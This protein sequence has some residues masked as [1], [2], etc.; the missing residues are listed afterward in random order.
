[1]SVAS[2]LNIGL[3]EYDARIRTFV[4][5][6]AAMIGSIAQ[7]LQ[8]LDTATP[9]IV[10]LGIGTGTLSAA[11]LDVW[12]DARIIGIDADPAMLESA[13][14][15]L[16]HHRALELRHGSF[17]ETA[18]PRCDAMVA[19]IALHHVSTSEAKQKLYAAAHAA[20]RPDGLL[21][22]ADCFPAREPRL[23]NRQ[24]QAWR[25]HL[26]LTYTREEAANYFTAWAAEDTYFP[27]DDELDW[28]RLAR[29]SP[30]VVFRA[31]GF[32]VIAAR[33]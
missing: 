10:D 19:C 25:A 28:L 21:I 16:G 4:P 1:M 5:H 22:A 8:L 20:L 23:A 31:D 3:G 12:P 15:R 33:R 11:C 32:A 24:R 26:Q 27:L 2:H 9:A 30:E 29:F 18:L 14:L 13:R 17:L 6:Y 7:T